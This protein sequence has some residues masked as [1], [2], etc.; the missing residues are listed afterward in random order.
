[1]SSDNSA[2]A[3]LLSIIVETISSLKLQAVSS[4]QRQSVASDRFIG[5]IR[6]D[7]LKN[8]FRVSITF[9]QVQNKNRKKH[10][11]AGL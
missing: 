3:A 2:I 8:N 6:T 11:K 10:R 5:P 7:C 1:M 4:E 9:F